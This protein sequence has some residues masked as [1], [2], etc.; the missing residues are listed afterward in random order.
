MLIQKNV[1]NIASGSSLLSKS[2]KRSEGTSTCNIS[3]I[4]WIS[5]YKAGFSSPDPSTESEL[6]KS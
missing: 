1:D 3:V 2:L 4:K 6:E 5:Y